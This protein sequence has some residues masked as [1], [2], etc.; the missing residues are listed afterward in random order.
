MV[1]KPLA[2]EPHN[3]GQQQIKIEDRGNLLAHL[4]NRLQLVG[5]LARF[6]EG[7][8]AGNRHR[9]LIGDQEIKR[10]SLASNAAGS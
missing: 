10:K 7:A 6:V 1:A 3:R 5:A 9:R 4:A 8:S 2:N